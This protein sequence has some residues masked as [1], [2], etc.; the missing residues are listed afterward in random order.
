M[1]TWIASMGSTTLHFWN[2]AVRLGTIP[3]IQQ[4]SLF[5]IPRAIGHQLISVSVGGFIRLTLKFIIDVPT[6]CYTIDSYAEYFVLVFRV[7]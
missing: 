1:G 7:F 6:I 5:A 3:S 4:A 2:I